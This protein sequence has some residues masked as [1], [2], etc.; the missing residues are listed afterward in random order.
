MDFPWKYVFHSVIFLSP[1]FWAH[2]QDLEKIS[3]FTYL[4]TGV[5][6]TLLGSFHFV[7]PAS[8][9]VSIICLSADHL[10][11][12]TGQKSWAS[13]LENVSQH[14]SIFQTSSILLHSRHW[15]SIC[16]DGLTSFSFCSTKLLYH[17][18]IPIINISL[19]WKISQFVHLP[20]MP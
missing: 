15:A 5:P 13:S 7:T 20:E 12:N 9:V 14:C 10:F 3:I 1:R 4:V 16:W 8:M 18:L 17:V 11:V 2:L 6:R 19:S